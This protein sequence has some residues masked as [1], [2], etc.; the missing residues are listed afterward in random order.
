LPAGNNCWRMRLL[1]NAAAAACC[2]WHGTNSSKSAPEFIDNRQRKLLH[3]SDWRILISLASVYMCPIHH[4]C[5]STIV[6]FCT[7][8]LNGANNYFENQSASYL[9]HAEHTDTIHLA[10]YFFDP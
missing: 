6:L 5:F 9:R 4:L 7:Q 1:E 10:C 8:L 3:F 2:L